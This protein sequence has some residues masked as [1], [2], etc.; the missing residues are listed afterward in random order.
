M[1]VLKHKENNEWKP[2]GGTGVTSL[3]GVTGDIVPNAVAGEF[4]KKTAD[5]WETDE[6]DLS[7]KQ[8]VISDL[9]TIRSGAEAGATAYQKPAGGIPDSDIASASTWNGKQAAL[10]SGTNIKTI[11]GNSLLGSGNINIQSGATIATYSVN[12]PTSSWTTV[13]ASNWY[14]KTITV[15]GI[16]ASDTP[17]VDIN[18]SSCTN[19]DAVETA[20]ANWG[21]IFRITTANNSITVY[22]SQIPTTQI[23]ITLRCIR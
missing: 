7:S 21:N 9:A 14:T 23:T 16:L 17:D 15:N 19:A 8:D 5:G 3:G 12:I 11:N 1:S 18:L 2:V 10:V 22:S 20:L 6:V 13:S 4:L